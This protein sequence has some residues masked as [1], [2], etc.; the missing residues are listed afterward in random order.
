MA[1]KHMKRIAAPFAW[2]V[3][4]KAGKFIARPRG[5]F[6]FGAGMPLMTVIKDVLGLVETRK[7]GKR[8]L[9]SRDVFVNGARRKDE[10]FMVG[11]MDLLSLKDLGK[12]YRVLFDTNGVLRLVP[13]SDSDASV[14][15]C[16][17]NGKRI[18]GKGKVQLSLHDGR[19]IIGSNDYRT[20]DS[21]VLSTQDTGVKGHVRLESGC[22]AYL[23]GGS[24]VGRMGV[25][26]SISGSNV[27]IRI[28]DASVEAAK[29][30][31][32]PVGKEK[33][34]ISIAVKEKTK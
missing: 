13:V 21:L 27:I 20:G 10:K 2:M 26:A 31:V 16:R 6:S 19:S 15:L 3:E 4:R 1:K 25:V 29:R 9:N 22:Y 30:F 33:P 18:I 34:L 14:H 5:S 11:I 24:N 12:T 17:I 32:F 7:E 8:V 28:G 23:I